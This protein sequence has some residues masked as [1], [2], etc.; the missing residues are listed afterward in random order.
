MTAGKQTWKK[1]IEKSDSKHAFAVSTGSSQMAA[2]TSCKNLDVLCQYLNCFGALPLW[3]TMLSENEK[4]ACAELHNLKNKFLKRVQKFCL[5]KI[6]LHHE[7]INSGKKTFALIT[8]SSISRHQR[9]TVIRELVERIVR[10]ISPYLLGCKQK[11]SKKFEINWW[12]WR[13]W[14]HCCLEN[15]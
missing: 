4:C 7:H 8:S 5:S 13:L 9:H 14:A 1:M 10:E 11:D 12:C 15:A 2:L 6:Y 3:I